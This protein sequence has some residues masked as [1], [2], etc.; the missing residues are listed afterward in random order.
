[1]SEAIYTIPC[2]GTITLPANMSESVTVTCGGGT[3][4]TPGDEGS[5][6][7]T[8]M[9]P[10]EWGALSLRI[11][12]S[13]VEVR[14]GESLEEAVRSQ[15]T[16]VNVLPEGSTVVIGAREGELDAES[17]ESVTEEITGLGASNVEMRII[18]PDE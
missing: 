13:P 1:M 11:V 14:A 5:T 18:S 15:V 17:V 6:G 7:S 2:G 9:P 3:A 16:G 4:P 8:T 10:P 12:T